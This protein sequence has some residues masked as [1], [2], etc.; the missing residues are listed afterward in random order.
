VYTRAS[1]TDILARKIACRTKVR[2]QVG[3][4]N[5]PRAEVGKE[6][7]VGV[8][9][10]VGPVELK[11]YRRRCGISCHRVSVCVCVCVCPSLAGTVSKRLN[12]ESH[13][14]R[15]TRLRQRSR[16]N[17]NRITS[18]GAP[19]AGRLGYNR[20]L[21]T[22][23]VASRGKK[24]ITRHNPKTVRDRRIVSIKVEEEVV[25]TLSNGY[26]A[27]DL[28]NLEPAKPPQFLHLATFS[29][30]PIVD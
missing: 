27:D 5:G 16:R 22:N 12:L 8:G 1:P 15:H 24:A 25:R 7:R 28:G 14:Q 3:E 11:L 4:L 10:R 17:L 20:P 26:V 29:Y 19:N 30:L 6:V 18:M 23:S 21:L 13:K 9:V 2:G